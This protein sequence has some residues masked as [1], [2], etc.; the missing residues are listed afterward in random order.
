MKKKNLKRIL[1]IVGIC[2]GILMGIIVVFLA[3]QI[4]KTPKLSEIDATPEGYLSTILDKNG[5]VVNNLYITESNRIYV[6][7]DSIPKE[8][9][10]A[11]IAI[12]DARF[13]KHNG[14]DLQGIV[15]AFFHGIVTREFSQGAST[16]T[17]QLLKNNVF[18]DWMNEVSFYDR[19]SR[20]VQ[21]QYLAVRL[22]QQYSKEWIL[23]N[24]LNTINLGGGTRGVQVATQYYFGKDVSQL[25]LAES[26]LLAGITKNPSAYNPL[27]H[28][29]K[30]KDRQ[31]LVL[32]AM[33]EQG[34]ITQEE[35]E[36]AKLEDVMEA[37]NTDSNN[38][39]MRV[40]SWFED[41]MLL[42]IVLLW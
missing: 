24:Y 3:I 1:S 17:Q 20:K 9:Q 21:E 18:T 32:N 36:T 4:V 12:E 19:L 5:N 28:P 2:I 14:I 35:Y 40:F 38:R 41:A 33:L 26:A 10:K 30:S 7:L 8:L 16:I 23:E 37:L 29:E 13:Y 22:E 11:F 27:T 42:Q 15:R 34:Y 39:G 6:S 25:S 31:L